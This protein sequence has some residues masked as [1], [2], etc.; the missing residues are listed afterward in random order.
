[1][2]GAKL[3]VEHW[4]VYV[5]G[6]RRTRNSRFRIAF[7]RP[8]IILDGDPARALYL[9]ENVPISIDTKLFNKR[10]VVESLFVIAG[11]QRL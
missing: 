6:A 7:N 1:M 4:R 2:L 11:W 5:K 10:S 3:R 9:F 8:I